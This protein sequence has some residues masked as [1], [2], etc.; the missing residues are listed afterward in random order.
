MRLDPRRMLALAAFVA[1]VL[2]TAT[3]AAATRS[4]AEKTL[5]LD[6][7]RRVAV[8]LANVGVPV[9]LTRTSDVTRSAAQRFGLA[10]RRRVDAFISIHYNSSSS[11]SPDWSEVYSQRAG[12]ASRTLAASIGS[13]LD[14][15]VGLPVK[16]KTRRGDHGDYYWQLRETN[17]PAT[18]VEGAFL[19]HPSRARL[20]A[21]S[22]AYRQR[23]ADA[24]ADGILAYQRTL[25]AEPL[26][27]SETPVRVVAAPFDA[28]SGVE[29]AAINARTVRLSWTPTALAPA[30]RVY[31]DGVLLGTVSRPLDDAVSSLSFEDRWAAPGQRYTYEL[32]AATLPLTLRAASIESVPVRIAVRTPPIVVALDAGHGGRDPGAVGRW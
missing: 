23:F 22:S 11:S 9:V 12:G 30:Y 1:V 7:T 16:L 13:A 21:T 25:V 29:A 17:M 31:R 18:I 20:L 10:N 28:P 19:S 2:P 24:I 8:R 3:G 14:R 32:V 15:R 5:N 6:I 27:S 26:P 4:V